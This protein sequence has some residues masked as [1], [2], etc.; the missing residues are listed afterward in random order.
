MT[1][2]PCLDWHWTPGRYASR[3]RDLLEAWQVT[4]RASGGGPPRLK[5]GQVYEGQVSLSGGEGP[6]RRWLVV[7]PFGKAHIH[8]IDDPAELHCWPLSVIHH[9]LAQGRMAYVED[10]PDHPVLK[11][12]RVKEARGLEDCHLGLRGEAVA[13]MLEILEEAVA[14]GAAYA[15]Y[16]ASELLAL[17]DRTRYAEEDLAAL[18]ARITG[19]LRDGSGRPG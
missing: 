17:L 18:A 4:D 12:Q 9:G 1:V 14:A 6:Q 3:R 8:S 13:A 11:L 16:A 10:R 19:L 5:E 2:R 7:A 15:P